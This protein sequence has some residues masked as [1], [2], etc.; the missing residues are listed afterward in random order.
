M[1]YRVSLEHKTPAFFE[2][3]R[4]VLVDASGAGQGRYV[5]AAVCVVD[6]QVVQL[7]SSPCHAVSS[8]EA[9]KECIRWAL[10]VMPNALVWNDCIPAIEAVL[11]TKPEL[12]G[13]L[14]WPSPKMRKPFHD[15]AHSLSTLARELT[16]CRV[17]TLDELVEN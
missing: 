17:W 10:D 8:V 11:K 9:E 5:M 16:Q 12:E 1:A 14:F 7:F 6:G 15:L 4:H 13:C 3:G 2:R